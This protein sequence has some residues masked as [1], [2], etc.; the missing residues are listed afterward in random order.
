M[1]INFYYALIDS[2]LAARFTGQLI[3]VMDST[4][5]LDGL[6]ETVEAAIKAEAPSQSQAAPRS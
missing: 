4:S 3:D 6:A 1:P 5:G 2:V